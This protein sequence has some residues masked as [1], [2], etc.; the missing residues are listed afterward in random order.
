M[1]LADTSVWIDHMRSK[2]PQLALL[3]EEGEVLTHPFVIGEIALGNLRSRAQWLAALGSLEQVP[4]AQNAEVMQFIEARGLAGA[5][6]GWV[7]AHL[8]A[9][10][11]LAGGGTLLTH[12][13]RLRKV[14][15]SLGLSSQLH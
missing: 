4:L 13:K 8:L 3:L 15:L 1:I 10:L 12:D 2:D 7:D 11:L 9:S 6:I 5:G 14:A